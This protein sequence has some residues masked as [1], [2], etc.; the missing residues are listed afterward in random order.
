M[1]LASSK[2]RQIV[3]D[4]WVGPL[5]RARK[6]AQPVAAS[7]GASATRLRRAQTHLTA[8]ADQAERRL[9]A[10][11][12]RDAVPFAVPVRLELLL[13]VF[14]VILQHVLCIYYVY[15]W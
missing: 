8:V 9:W 14:C 6:P 15:S 5:H 12:A 10:W 7:L 13:F 4:Q 11:P 2:T 3:A 1:R